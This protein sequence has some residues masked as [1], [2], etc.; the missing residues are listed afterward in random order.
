MQFTDG[1]PEIRAEGGEQY[2]SERLERFLADNARL[3]PLE[4]NAKLVS[5]LHAY[6]KGNFEDD[7]FLMSI[8][9]R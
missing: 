4:F 1:V 7:L 5:D 6:S 8:R 9:T 2:G 3:M